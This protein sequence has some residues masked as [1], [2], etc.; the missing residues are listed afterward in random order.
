MSTSKHMELIFG[1][2]AVAGCVAAALPDNAGGQA[3]PKAAA[4]AAAAAAATAT[5]DIPVVVVKGKRMSALEKRELSRA[6]TVLRH[7]GANGS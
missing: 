3:E 2:V 5:A 1:V 6:D 7:D 4:A